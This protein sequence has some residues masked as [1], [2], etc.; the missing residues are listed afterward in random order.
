MLLSVGFHHCFVLEELLTEQ[1]R[2]E[3]QRPSLTTI[4][5]RTELLWVTAVISFRSQKRCPQKVLK[6]G[7]T[8]SNG[9]LS[10]VLSPFRITITRGGRLG[11]C[12][13]CLYPRLSVKALNCNHYRSTPTN[14]F[15]KEMLTIRG[16]QDSWVGLVYNSNK[17]NWFGFMAIHGGYIYSCEI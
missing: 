17:Q 8:K 9:S 15:C 2:K 14:R 7:T 4:L 5:T 11:S 12:W 13:T 10:S 16:P 3:S 1:Q 6:F